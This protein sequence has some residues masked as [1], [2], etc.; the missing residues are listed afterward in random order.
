MKPHDYQSFS[1]LNRIGFLFRIH[2]ERFFLSRFPAAVCT[3]TDPGG[4]LRFRTGAGFDPDVAIGFAAF[5]QP[6]ARQAFPFSR[7]RNS[8]SLRM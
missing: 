3:A 2:P 5:S 1:G 6:A 7:S 8:G 4:L